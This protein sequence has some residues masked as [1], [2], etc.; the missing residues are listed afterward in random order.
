VPDAG[1]FE[2]ALWVALATLLGLALLGRVRRYAPAVAFAGL[3]AY[4]VW[5]AVVETALEP[6]RSPIWDPAVRAHWLDLDHGLLSGTFG[7]LPHLAVQLFHAVTPIAGKG[8]AGA[9]TASMLIG[10]AAIIAIYVLGRRVAGT[11]GGIAAA[12]VALMADP[13]RLS[14]SEGS[15]VGTL[16]LA[17]CLFLIAVHRVLR[18]A[19]RMAMVLLGLA[20]ALAILAQPLWWPG[21]LASIVLLALRLAPPGARRASLGTALLVLALVSLPSRVSVA[22][23]YDGDLAADVV[24]QATQAR[25]AEFVGR[26]HGAP[27]NAEA[28]ANDP[29]GGPKV[30]LGDYVVGDHSA[31]VVVGGTLS[32]AYDSVTA[33]ARRPE[34]GLAGLLAFLVGLVGV[35]FLA[36]AP[37]LRLLVVVPALVALVPWFFVSRD[38]AEPFAAVAAFWPALLVG[39][40]S[41]AY[42]LHEALKRRVG[43][44]AWA[45]AARGRFA[46]LTRRDRRQ[47]AQPVES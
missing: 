11:A 37:R 39:A 8:T 17:A 42:A 22:H 15:A 23:Q 14:L 5:P 44:P 20:G 43:T 3:T 28:L 10:V 41:V 34:S 24:L 7:A 46:S 25:N 38:V 9:A 2:V 27:E 18:G 33:A 19:D 36:L 31:S 29:S 13:F 12:T 32:G 35:V 26:G 4:L 30:G 21:V 40:A 1:R 6:T 47:R 45:T 16:V